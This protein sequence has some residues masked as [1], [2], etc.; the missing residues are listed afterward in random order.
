MKAL[1]ALFVSAVAAM[2][3]SACGRSYTPNK[4]F[5][6]NEPVADTSLNL[7]GPVEDTTTLVPLD[8][9][10]LRVDTLN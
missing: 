10:S 7:I 3:V 8:S 6:E 9:D 1:K 2:L 4:E 5:E